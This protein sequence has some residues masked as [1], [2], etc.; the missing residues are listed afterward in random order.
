MQ[1]LMA[2]VKPA[3]T[4]TVGMASFPP[5]VH[6]G[7]A[8][9]SADTSTTN[10]SSNATSNGADGNGATSPPGVPGNGGEV[11]PAASAPAGSGAGVGSRSKA[12]GVSLAGARV[13]VVKDS[14]PNRKLLVSLLHHMGCQA[15]GV[16]NGQQCVDLFPT[17]A[18]TALRAPF[19]AVLMV[20]THQRICSLAQLSSVQLCS[21]Q[22]APVAAVHSR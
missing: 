8:S 15:V 18:D 4:T 20:S 22:P 21:A 5:H 19:D 10:A 9:A 2:S 16:E 1:N 3:N 11:L 14:A 13:L 17:H 6:R 7:L 12:S